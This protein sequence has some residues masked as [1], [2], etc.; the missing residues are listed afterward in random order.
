MFHFI[1]PYKSPGTNIGGRNRLNS[2]W[3]EQLGVINVLLRLVPT[4][5][6]GA[7]KVDRIF[8]ETKFEVMNFI[9]WG[10]QNLP[11]SISFQSSNKFS[12]CANLSFWSL[13]GHYVP[14]YNQYCYKL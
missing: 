1:M 5:D 8:Y 12:G 9:I 7:R 3:I 2:V 4:I 14:I 6:C 13:L 11:I 10:V